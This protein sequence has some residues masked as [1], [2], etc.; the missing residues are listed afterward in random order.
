MRR[1]NEIY[2]INNSNLFPGKWANY[3]FA[4]QNFNRRMDL[5][6]N[7]CKHNAGDEETK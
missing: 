6:A 4:D 3:S 1:I 7:I 2:H 5:L